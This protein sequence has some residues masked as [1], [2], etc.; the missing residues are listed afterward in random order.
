MGTNYSS[1]YKMEKNKNNISNSF[2]IIFLAAAKL[3]KLQQLDQ[4][5]SFPTDTTVVS[6][7]G[8]GQVGTYF[9]TAPEIEQGWP[10]IDEKVIGCFCLF[11]SWNSFHVCSVALQ[12][13]NY[14]VKDY[15]T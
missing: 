9:Y 10:K 7:D 4:D 3:L 12:L 5:V 11:P 15:V 2:F 8:T 14:L 6:I 13:N 1:N